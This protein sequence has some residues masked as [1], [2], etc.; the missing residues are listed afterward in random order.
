MKKAACAFLMLAALL[1]P[2]GCGA[3]RQQLPEDP[4]IFERGEYLPEG[5][6]T[7][8]A[9]VEYEGRIYIPYASIRPRLFGDLTYA[10]GKCLGHVDGDDRDRIYALKDSPVEQWLIEYY[11]DAVMELPIVLREANTRG[12]EI[13]WCMESLG[14]EGAWRD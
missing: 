10:F 5:A 3:K 11:E 7:P 8:D 9:T 2:A 4:I 14:W 1:M 13:P 6:I 12:I